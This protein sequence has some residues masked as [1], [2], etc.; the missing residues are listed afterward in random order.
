M[1]SLGLSPK[2]KSDSVDE[3]S[4]VSLDLRGGEHWDHGR[5][6]T[7]LINYCILPRWLHCQPPP[8]NDFEAAVVL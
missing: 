5:K 3:M 6:Q 1:R 2:R 4:S 7:R 8:P